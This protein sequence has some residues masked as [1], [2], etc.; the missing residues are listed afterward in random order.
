MMTNTVV[1]HVGFAHSGTTSLQQNIFSQR[2]DIF[3][4][5]I[6]YGDLGGIFSNIKYRDSGFDAESVAREVEIRIRSKA[7]N[8]QAIVVS[9]ETFVEQP[10]VYYTPAMLPVGSIAER[11]HTLFPDA[12]VLLT[13]RNQ[14]DYV[15]SMY[16]NLKRNYANLANRPIEPMCEWISGNRTQVANLFLR[17]LDYSPAIRTYVQ[18]FGR[19]AV[20]VVPLESLRQSGPRAYLETIGSHLGIAMTE[21]DAHRF[22]VIRNKRM[23]VLEDEIASRWHDPEFRRFYALLSAAVGDQ[24]LADALTELPAA[25]VFLQAEHRAYIEKRAAAG[26]VYIVEEF[27]VP[28]HLYGYPLPGAPTPEQRIA[29]VPTGSHGGTSKE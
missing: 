9:D 28:L 27:C 20:S 7:A 15:I 3:Y 16:L 29:G 17:N 23:T 22:R 19:E 1:L 18:I 25:Q 6:P 24:T 21:D 26:N 13:I 2:P 8:A 10:E 14:F 12:R 4:C 5:G 11:L